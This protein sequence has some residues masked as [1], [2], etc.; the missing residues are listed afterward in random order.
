MPSASSRALLAGAAAVLASAAPVGAFAPGGSPGGPVVVAAFALRT[1]APLTTAGI[2]RLSRRTW[3]GGPT[4]AADGE[5]VTVFVS[6]SYA[7]DPSV[8]QRWADFFAGLVHGSELGLLTTYVETPAE[9]S[10]TCGGES[11]LGCY[12]SNRLVIPGD[13]DQGVDPTEIATHE[14]GHHIAFNRVDTPWQAVDWGTKRWS[15]YVNVCAKSAAGTMFPGDEDVH[16]RQNPGEAFAEVYRALN[17]S[18]KGLALDWPIVDI[19]FF[20]DPNAIQAVEQDVLQP[21]ATGTARSITGRFTARG[22]RRFTL[23]LATPLDGD[24]Q[25]SLSLPKGGLYDV[26]LLAAD[27]RSVLAKGLWSG[28]RAKTLA[29]T[30]CGQRSM[31]VRVSRIGAPG[32]FALHLVTP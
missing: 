8:V 2:R 26:T 22:K 6:D 28:L 13:V 5:T 14:Y 10:K 18:K 12:G 16:Y 21:W 17:Y 23:P 7:A 32:R 19:L 11:I 25:L 15:S 29:F 20:P 4:T 24:L 27:G 31:L 1:S 3:S 30:I 9:V